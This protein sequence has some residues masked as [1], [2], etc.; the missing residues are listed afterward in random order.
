MSDLNKHEHDILTDY[1]FAR[2]LPFI[3]KYK[4]LLISIALLFAIL[5]S[6]L[7][8]YSMYSSGK[9][10]EVLNSIFIQLEKAKDD[11]SAS[12]LSKLNK[13]YGKH[14][15]SLEIKWRL[16]AAHVNN[17]EYSEAADVYREIIEQFPDNP[18]AVHAVLGL[19]SCLEHEKKY[20]EAQNLYDQSL[21]TYENPNIRAYF[22]YRKAQAYY[23]MQ[24]YSQ[25]KQTAEQA[26]SALQGIPEENKSFGDTLEKRIEYIIRISG[27]KLM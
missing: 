9:E 27:V 25:S 16:A 3:V 10:K 7:G 12:L 23:F 2:L 15:A 5:L 8:F 20:K 14:P 4:V 6:V 13:T 17:K 19:A 26:L 18:L 22:L 1:F 24:E 11:D 21:D